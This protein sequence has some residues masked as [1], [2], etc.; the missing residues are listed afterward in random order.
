MKRIRIR[1]AVALDGFRARLT[2][3]NGM[4]LERNLANA[5]WGEVFDPVRTDPTVFRS[6]RI[7]GRTIA[8]PNGADICPDA[9]IWGGAPPKGDAFPPA[10]LRDPEKAHAA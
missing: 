4:V 8:W 5:L 10:T 1:D 6:F 7:E 3:T 9:L 2:L